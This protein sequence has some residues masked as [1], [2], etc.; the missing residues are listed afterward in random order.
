PPDVKDPEYPDDPGV[1]ADPVEDED[2]ETVVVPQGP[3]LQ[4][5]KTSD[6]VD[7]AVAGEIISYS[8]TATNIGNVTLTDVSITDPL[9]GL[10]EL[11]YDWPGETGELQPGQSVTATAIYTVTRADVD[12]GH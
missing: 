1:P 8:F 10:S 3:A 7:N 12:R 11:S 9:N 4:L 6:A 2:P 5:V